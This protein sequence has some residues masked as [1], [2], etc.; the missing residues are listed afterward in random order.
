MATVNPTFNSQLPALQDL[1]PFDR[2]EIKVRDYG[3]LSATVGSFGPKVIASASI[4]VGPDFDGFLEL[5]AVDQ[6]Y[7]NPVVRIS[8]RF[9]DGDTRKLCSGVQECSGV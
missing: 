5:E 8:V 6:S 2:V 3:L 4:P 7:G 9:M 1:G